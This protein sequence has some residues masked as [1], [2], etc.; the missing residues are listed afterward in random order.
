[1]SFLKEGPA[2]AFRFLC[3]AKILTLVD[4]FFYMY[5]HEHFPLTFYPYFSIPRLQNA[6]HQA[7]EC[8]ERIV[9]NETRAGHT[10]GEPGKTPNPTRPA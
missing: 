9:R 1:M 4:S 3:V 8:R 7:T 5:S 10:S 6:H 2:G